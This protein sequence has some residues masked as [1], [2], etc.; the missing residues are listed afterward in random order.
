[1]LFLIQIRNT[2]VDYNTKQN[3][4]FN[5]ETVPKKY[6]GIRSEYSNRQ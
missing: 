1:M 6:D 3:T 5:M 4:A 2:T